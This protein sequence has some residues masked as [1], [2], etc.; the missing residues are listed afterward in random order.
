MFASDPRG[1]RFDAFEVPVLLAFGLVDLAHGGGMF[2]VAS[3]RRR[4]RS[5][6]A[7]KRQASSA[8]FGD[9]RIAPGRAVNA[10]DNDLMHGRGVSALVFSQ[11]RHG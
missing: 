10:D 4:A 6:R 1:L 7:L 3:L 11:H 8:A 5:S 2:L 9:G